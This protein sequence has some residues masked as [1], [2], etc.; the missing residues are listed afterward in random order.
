MKSL[1]SL[2][3]TA[4]LATAATSALADDDYEIIYQ[5]S[6]KKNPFVSAERAAESLEG[7]YIM[8]ALRAQYAANIYPYEGLA[9]TRHDEV[10][11]YAISFYVTFEEPSVV[12]LGHSYAP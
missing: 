11:S 6:E 4:I 10:S 9:T 1:L 12:R 7:G 5:A 3:T 2:A 8:P